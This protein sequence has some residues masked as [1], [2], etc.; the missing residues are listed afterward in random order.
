MCGG[1]L[2]KEIF[3]QQTVRMCPAS[4]VATLT[5]PLA[6]RRMAGEERLFEATGP[7]RYST[8]VLIGPPS[9][10]QRYPVQICVDPRP[11]ALRIAVV[12]EGK[13]KGLWAEAACSVTESPEGS[14]LRYSLRYETGSLHLAFLSSRALRKWVEDWLRSAEAVGRD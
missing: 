14:L 7:G 2:L 5:N 4:V 11:N 6:L 12:G 13:A 10:G 8:E 3:G 9:L 1:V